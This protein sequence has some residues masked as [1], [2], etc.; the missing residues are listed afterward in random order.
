MKISDHLLSIFKKSKSWNVTHVANPH[1]AARSHPYPFSRLVS[2]QGNDQAVNTLKRNFGQEF[3]KTKSVQVSV[4]IFSKPTINQS[5]IYDFM[6][7]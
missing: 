5:E 4:F 2:V 1:A 7:T 6:I 3:Q